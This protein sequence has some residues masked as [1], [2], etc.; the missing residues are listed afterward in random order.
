MILTEW[1]GEICEAD[2][3]PKTRYWHK[4]LETCIRTNDGKCQWA[5]AKTPRP[6]MWYDGDDIQRIGCTGYN[7]VTGRAEWIGIDIDG[8]SHGGGFDAATIAA[9]RDRMAKNPAIDLYES[10]SGD[11]LHGI[12]R[13][14]PFVDVP[15]PQLTQLAAHVVESV[16]AGL[17]KFIDV[18]GGNLWLWHC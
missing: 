8:D 4:N 3:E 5:N 10:T 14:N 6:E 1:V 2:Q 12:I 16:D 11:G 15:K 9:L 17:T 13:L 7:F 18:A